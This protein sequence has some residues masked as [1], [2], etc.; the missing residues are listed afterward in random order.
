MLHTH[1]H[2]GPTGKGIPTWTL[3]QKNEGTVETKQKPVAMGDWTTYGT[4]SPERTPFQNGINRQSHLQKV[5]RERRI[6]HTYP[7]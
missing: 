2:P 3:C 1:Y 6:S 7:I 4:L 5:F